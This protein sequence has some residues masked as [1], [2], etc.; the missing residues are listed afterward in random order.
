VQSRDHRRKN[1][2][3]MIYRDLRGKRE[4]LPSFPVLRIHRDP[5]WSTGAD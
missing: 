2:A 4:I 1:G 3:W 5:A